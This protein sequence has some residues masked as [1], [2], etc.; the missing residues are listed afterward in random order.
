MQKKIMSIISIL[1]LIALIAFINY[2]DRPVSNT[3][4]GAV[5][6]IDKNTYYAVSLDFSKDKSHY[7]MGQ[8]YATAILQMVPNYEALVDSYLSE[9]TRSDE[10]YNNIIKK[11]NDIKPKIDKEYRDEIKGM[12]SKFSGLGQGFL[13]NTRGDGKISLDELYIMNLIPDVVRGTQCSALAVYGDRSETKQSIVGR[14]LDWY[15]GS[16]D[17][18]AK[19]QAVTTFNDSDKSICTIGYLGYIGVISGFN[20]N[21]VFAAILDSST[22]KT[23]SS[24]GKDSYP[25][26]LRH[27]L[28]NS[29]SLDNVGN[30]LKAAEKSYAC[31]HLIFLS[32]PSI[33]K[34]LENNISTDSNSIRDF[35][36]GNSTLNKGV[37]WDIDNSIGCVNS[38]LLK[39]NFDNHSSTLPNTTRWNS[40][41]QELKSKG[42]A[43]SLEQM[44]NI[45]AFHYGK[46]PDDPSTGD[47]YNIN[48]QQIILFQ[49]ED[50]NLQIFFKSRNGVLPNIPSFEKISITFE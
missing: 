44:K 46:A 6:I 7:K 19:I 36:T 5:T 48:T 28:E 45:V 21:K 9:I 18:L 4:I 12:A 35:R 38:F 8:D 39:G 1:F 14:I 26:D 27:A 31:S 15:P 37:Q 41:K 50:F 22:G 32:D 23:Y 3:S 33:S 49:P 25:L 16:I 42:N 29:T 13:Q 30:Y 10:D 24:Q 40:M 43:V 2:N 34:V 20:N 17:Q 47:L 11:A